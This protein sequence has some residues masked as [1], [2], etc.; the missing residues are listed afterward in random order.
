MPQTRVKVS[1]LFRSSVVGA[2]QTE[3]V[4][5]RMAF[6]GR[7]NPIIGDYVLVEGLSL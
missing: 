3:V 2:L 6:M 1:A 5:L 7:F 4:S